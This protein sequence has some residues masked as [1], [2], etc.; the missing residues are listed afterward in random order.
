[1][2]AALDELLAGDIAP[3]LYEW[4][5]APE[6]DIAGA[7]HGAGWR[8]RELD[9]GRCSDA[10]SFY[11]ALAVQWDLPE[12]FGRNLDALWDVLGDL[13]QAPLLVIWSGVGELATLDPQLAQSV[14]ELFRDASTQATS[15]AVVVTGPAGLEDL[16]VSGLDGLL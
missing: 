15:L 1:M 3:G 10:A 7:A 8:V 9:T 14:L 11:A 16:G 13:A 12:W 4:C 6:H 5:G 2:T